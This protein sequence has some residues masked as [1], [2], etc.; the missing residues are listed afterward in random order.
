MFARLAADAQVPVVPIVTAGAGES[1][2]VLDDGQV[3]A[4]KLGVASA[5]RVKA[6]PL[7]ISIPWGLS[8]GITGLLP[9][10]PLPTKLRTS[11]LPAMRPG[12]TETTDDFGRRV[13]RAMQDRLDELT[14]ARRWVL[15]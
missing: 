3:I 5:L 2:L 14:A 1:L 9:Y 8:V 13:Q 10:L 6:L 12:E 11:V 15:G 7:S 4:R